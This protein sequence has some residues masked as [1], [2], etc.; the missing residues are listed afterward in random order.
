MNGMDEFLDSLFLVLVLVV[1]F[2]FAGLFIPGV[3]LLLG[4][5]PAVK[6]IVKR[7]KQPKENYELHIAFRYYG[8]YFILS[9]ISLACIIW[10]AV[11]Y[12]Y[13]LRF[14][15]AVFFILLHVVNFVYAPNGDRFL[16]K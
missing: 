4:K 6:L 7:L 8:V 15:A 11:F 12:L 3:L 16:K 2:C 9:A 10:G 14:G 5:G 1:P 13:G